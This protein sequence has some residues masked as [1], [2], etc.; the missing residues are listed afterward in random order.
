[1]EAFAALEFAKEIGFTRIIIE[2]DALGL[3]VIHD[4]NS[5]LPDMSAIGNY[6]DE[7]QW[8]RKDFQTCEVKYI[9]Y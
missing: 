8:R 6:V 1:M 3:G 2:G 4:I 7:A 5:E 9:L